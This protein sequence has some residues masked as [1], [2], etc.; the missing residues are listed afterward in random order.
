[1]NSVTPN[2]PQAATELSG[3]QNLLDSCKVPGA[4]KAA[5][6]TEVAIPPQADP[7]HEAVIPQEPSLGMP[8]LELRQVGVQV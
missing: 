2:A 4:N 8:L 7:H 3:V 6:P 5:I 1:M